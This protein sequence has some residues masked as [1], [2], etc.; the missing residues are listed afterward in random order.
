MSEQWILVV[1]ELR[2]GVEAGVLLVLVIG[3]VGANIDWYVLEQ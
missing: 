3:A 1:S 2:D